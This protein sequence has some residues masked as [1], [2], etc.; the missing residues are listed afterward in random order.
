MV[1]RGPER[2]LGERRSVDD[3]RSGAERR[4]SERRLFPIVLEVGQRA[5]EDRR[6]DERR[7]YLDGR[8]DGRDRRD[9]V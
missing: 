9:V 7:A 1:R 4:L 2:R 6:A 5:G 8:R 3:R